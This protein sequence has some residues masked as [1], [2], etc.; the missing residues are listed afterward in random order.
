M[1]ILDSEKT[2]SLVG[3]ANLAQN[4]QINKSIKE[5]MKSQEESAEAAKR[6]ANLQKEANNLEKERLAAQRDTAR[7]AQIQ[8]KIAQQAEE[9]KILKE[10]Q[11]AWEKQE[12]KIKKETLFNLKQDIQS[13]ED[14]NNIEIEKYFDLN[15]IAVSL[16]DANISSS[17]FEAFVDKEYF[18]ETKNKLEEEIK[19]SYSSMSEEEIVDLET[20]NEILSDNEEL[21]IGAIN[22]KIAKEKESLKLIDEIEEAIEN[23]NSLLGLQTIRKVI[24]DEKLFPRVN[25]IIKVLKKKGFIKN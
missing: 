6:S 9:R 17:D 12:L 4:R 7:S 16:K 2:Q 24:E 15:S 11:E 10:K 13:I 1:G 25:A 22:K 20:I 8:L 3:I 21:K 19:K 14:S 5:L 18:A 23:E